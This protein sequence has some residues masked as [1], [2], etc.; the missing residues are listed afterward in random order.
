VRRLRTRAPASRGLQRAKT[1]TL[2]VIEEARVIA[3][4]RAH[5]VGLWLEFGTLT[6]LAV[7]SFIANQFWPQYVGESWGWMLL[8]G[9]LP[10]SALALAVPQ[11]GV[12]AVVI[13]SVGLGFNTVVI[14]TIT[15]TP[16]HGG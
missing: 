10:W 11:M 5:K 13:V 8:F 1:G 7:A 16:S 12:F 2:G 15:G 14:T 4:A 6:L 3:F 9:S